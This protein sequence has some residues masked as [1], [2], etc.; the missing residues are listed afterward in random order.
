MNTKLSVSDDATESAS[1]FARQMP[2]L[3]AVDPNLNCKFV[4]RIVVLQDQLG[5][6]LDVHAVFTSRAADPN[7]TV[8]VKTLASHINSVLSGARDLW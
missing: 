7:E 6:G 8:T 2:N 4:V 5:P 1:C 3:V